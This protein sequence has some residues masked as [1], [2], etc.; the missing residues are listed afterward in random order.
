MK[1]YITQN[2]PYNSNIYGNNEYAIKDHFPDD[3]LF[4]LYREDYLNLK[5][6]FSYIKESDFIVVASKNKYIEKIV[7]F[8]IAEALKYRKKIYFY[9]KGIEYL[10]I[11]IKICDT[12]N[13]GEVILKKIS[14]VAQE[15]PEE[16]INTF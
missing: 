13:F 2:F 9:K 3:S 1:F 16:T 15:E 12:P 10:I 7:F 5:K 14:K 6:R 11:G 8:E 4:P